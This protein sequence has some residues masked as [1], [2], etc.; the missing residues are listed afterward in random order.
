MPAE[1]SGSTLWCSLASDP[2]RRRRRVARANA[3]SPAVT[4]QPLDSR[5]DTDELHELKSFLAIRVVL[6][7]LTV[8]FG[9]HHRRGDKLD[10]G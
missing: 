5:L 10:P 8:H 9:Y 2:R 7:L 4:F 3:E 6:R 1:S